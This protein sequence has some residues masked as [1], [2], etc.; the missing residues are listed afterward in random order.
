MPRCSELQRM[1]AMTMIKV[2][3]DRPAES[4]TAGPGRPGAPHTGASGRPAAVRNARRHGAAPDRYPVTG[5][6]GRLRTV[7]SPRLKGPNTVTDELVLPRVASGDPGAVRECIDRYG[8]LVWSLA[9]RL[10]PSTSEAE[11][12]VQE[13]FV[14]LWRSSGRFNPE[15]GSEATFIATIARRRLIDRARRRSRRLTAA[16]LEEGF[17]EAA[18]GRDGDV[19]QETT[20]RT[21]DA[22]LALEVLG[23]LSE[24]QQRVLRMSIL[25]GVSHEK[26]ATATGMPLGTVKTHIRRGLIKARTRL[27]EIKRNRSQGSGEA[28]GAAATLSAANGSSAPT[29]GSA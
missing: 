16:P 8:G 14:S 25:H 21:E 18:G 11:D 23:E 9:R 13:I 15:M 24:D 27:D 2:T 1:E 7:S 17:A 5:C 10:C 12:A 6:R 29:G 19:A 20:E 26:I 28:N 3:L 22:K 4:L